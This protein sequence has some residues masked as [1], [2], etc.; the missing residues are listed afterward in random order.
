MVEELVQR[1]RRGIDVTCTV[2]QVA[3]V[4]PDGVVE[5][6][7]SVQSRD[8]EVLDGWVGI[9]VVEPLGV[10]DVG[11]S[12]HASATQGTQCDHTALPTADDALEGVVLGGV[13]DDH[14]GVVETVVEHGE[15][16][17]ACEVH[18]KFSAGHGVVQHDAR[19]GAVEHGRHDLLVLHHIAV[20]DA[21]GHVELPLPVASELGVDLLDETVH[22]VDEQTVGVGP[23]GLHLGAARDLVDASL[24]EVRGGD[25]GLVDAS[26]DASAL[27]V[28][29]VAVGHQLLAHVGQRHVCAVD[30]G[31]NLLGVRSDELGV[32]LS[33]GVAKVLVTHLLVHH[34]GLGLVKVTGREVGNRDG[35]A[36]CVTLLDW[37]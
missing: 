21:L 1:R 5:E 24:E 15:Y 35:V 13:V 22:G 10:D 16:L 25:V 3:T 28:I 34:R 31:L 29:D 23:S 2:F 33:V 9:L 20:E 14:D 30:E 19:V 11:V 27:V 7:Q 32:V 8:I 12:N 4:R 18:G 17:L 26:V 6:S 37:H 36:L